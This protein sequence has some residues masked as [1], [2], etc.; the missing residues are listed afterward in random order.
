MIFELVDLHTITNG[1]FGVLFT[2]LLCRHTIKCHHHLLCRNI[3]LLAFPRGSS[4]RHSWSLSLQEVSNSVLLQ[5]DREE[6][7]SAAASGPELYRGGLCDH[8]D[9]STRQLFPL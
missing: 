5:C 9:Q 4:V 1:V 6:Q 7:P 3:A 8:Q 2:C